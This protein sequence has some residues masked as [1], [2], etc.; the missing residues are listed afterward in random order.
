MPISDARC[1]RPSA[2]IVAPANSLQTVMV[3][4]D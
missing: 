1:P 4:C 2:E 3:A